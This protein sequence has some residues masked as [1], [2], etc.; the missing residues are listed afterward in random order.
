MSI[1]SRLYGHLSAYAGLT[2]LVATR[3]Y[4]VRMPQDVA[5]PA[6]SYQEISG[7]GEHPIKGAAVA[8]K[9]RYQFTAWAKTTATKSGHLQ[10]REVIDQVKA[11]LWTFPGVADGVTVFEVTLDIGA[12]DDF[13]EASETD[14]CDLDVVILHDD[15]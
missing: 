14:R 5:L 12:R 11:A 3:I 1:E 9:S 4:P 6:L 7:P 15:V 8:L 2:S 13:D 10:A